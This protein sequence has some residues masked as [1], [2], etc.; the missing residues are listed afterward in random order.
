[1]TQ[2]TISSFPAV[3]S[4]RCCGSFVFWTV[5][6]VK[7]QHCCCCHWASWRQDLSLSLTINYFCSNPCGIWIIVQNHS[8]EQRELTLTSHISIS[9]SWGEIFQTLC[10]SALI[11]CWECFLIIF[12]VLFCSKWHCLMRAL[13][14]QERDAFYVRS[15]SSSPLKQHFQ[16]S[17]WS[18]APNVSFSPQWLIKPPFHFPSFH[19]LTHPL[20]V[21][22]APTP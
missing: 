1:M 17:T 11:H 16:R 5:P 21:C 2:E 6:K 14:K 13:D 19:M 10:A 3:L 15:F 8:L 7:L 22:Q 12:F 4:F 18:I 9:I 20:R